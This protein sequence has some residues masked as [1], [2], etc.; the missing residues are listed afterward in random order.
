M[1]FECD[2][3]DA[4]SLPV[5]EVLEFPSGD[6]VHVGDACFVGPFDKLLQSVAVI[7]YGC[8]CKFSA[9]VFYVVFDGFSW[10]GWFEHWCFSL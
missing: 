5:F 6:A 4:V 3:G 9:N 7:C 1:V 10:C 2:F 8:S